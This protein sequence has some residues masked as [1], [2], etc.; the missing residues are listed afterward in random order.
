M[1][2]LDKLEKKLEIDV[3]YFLKGGFWLG[4]SNVSNVSR[5]L[6]IGIVFA[7]FLPKESFGAFTYVNS[8]FLITNVFGTPG[9]SV[10]IVQSV[11]R[12]YEGTFAYLTKKVFLWSIMGTF[13]MFFAGLYDE[14]F[15][16]GEFSRIF[17]LLG[18]I[19]PF[20]SISVNFVYYLVAVKKFH[21]RMWMELGQ[22]AAIIVSI[23]IVL[24]SHGGLLWLVLA[25]IL[26]QTLTGL[27]YIAYLMRTSNKKIDYSSNKYGKVLN[28]ANVLP[29][30]KMQIDKILVANFLG[31]AST[32]TYNI[33]AALADQVYAF[34]KIIATMVVPKS[35]NMDHATLRKNL[36]RILA[37]LAL[38]FCSISMILFFLYPYL[39]PFVFGG[40]YEDAI[41]YAQVITL[42]VGIKSIT[43]IIQQIS[44]S[45]KD[46]KSTVFSSYVG[47][48]IELGLMLLF[49]VKYQI[50]GI[51]IA[52][53]IS[54]SLNLAVVI[55][56]F[57][58][59]DNVI[60]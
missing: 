41:L 37:Y 13:F 2:I 51:I 38:L 3:K 57:N 28:L 6:I 36:S 23:A 49:I 39:I 18:F 40:Q 33:A 35:A 34:A 11:A 47:P 4:L 29:T 43:A 30:A 10:A 59:G 48:F 16:A 55:F 58:K 25:P 14:F 21:I 19:F 56:Y 22:N 27:S 52:K 32:A 9:M 54:D 46:L 50:F 7:R 42:F 15:A 1:K 12:G 44:Q 8:I 26:A 24:L 60:G 5:L 45:K 17:F 31:Y 53:T 20:Y